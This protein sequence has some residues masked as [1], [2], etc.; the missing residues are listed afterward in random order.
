[1]TTIS[2]QEWFQMSFLSSPADIVIWWSWAWVGKTFSLLL[3]WL[4][5]IYNPWFNFVFFRRTRPEITNAWGMRDESQKVYNNIIGAKQSISSLQRT[6]PSGASGRFAGIEHE[7]DIYNRQGSQ[8]CMIWFDE[9]CHF[10]KTQFFYLMSRNRSTC[11]VRPYIRCTCNPD[12]YSRVA[13]F[14]SRW[15]D[16]D[17]WYPIPERAWKIRYFLQD[18]DSYLRGDSVEDLLNQN[19]HLRDREDFKINDPKDLIKTVTFI[20]W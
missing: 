15:I 20:P 2:P 4:R 11:W 19:P 7:K 1:M 14:I 10:S 6:F 17:T 12:P 13:E 8:I 16:P 9:L 3:E 5:N 18:Q